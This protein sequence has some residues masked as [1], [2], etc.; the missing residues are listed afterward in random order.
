M[1]TNCWEYTARQFTYDNLPMSVEE[2]REKYI[3]IVNDFDIPFGIDEYVYI[4][5]FAAGGMSSGVVGGKFVEDAL[6][7]LC[8]RLRKYG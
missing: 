2:F 6:E 7:L 4:E 1:H 3:A 8:K 5:K